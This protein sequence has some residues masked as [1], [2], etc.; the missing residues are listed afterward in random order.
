MDQSDSY[1][2]Q[3]TRLI[4]ALLRV[5][6]FTVIDS[7]YNGL[8]EAG[9][10]D[11]RKAHLAVWRHIDEAAGSRLTDLADEAQMTKQSM[12]YLV[13]YLEE[14]GY[15]ERVPDPDDGRAI[16]VRLTQRGHDV[17]AVARQVVTRLQD[18]WGAL[19][20]KRQMQQMMAT[21]RHLVSILES[22]K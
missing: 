21:L 2:D 22:R 7:I 10:D 6:Y 15:L 14:S 11:L 20:G 19:V 18:E 5:P 9:F 1:P 4:G 16:R 8:L 12:G 17:M 3:S 13:D